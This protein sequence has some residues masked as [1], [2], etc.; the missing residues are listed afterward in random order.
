[1][2]A[3][4]GVTFHG[5]VQADSIDATDCVFAGGLQVTQTQLGCVRFSHLGDSLVGEL[6][7]THQCISAPP[8]AFASIGFE[9][10]EY[11]ALRLDVHAEL[12]TASSSGGMI[13]AY[14]HVNPG[15]RID[16]LR[17]RLGEFGPLG[18]RSRVIVPRGEEPS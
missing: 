5:P 18:Q 15:A 11:L 12:H 13:G 10:A 4:R 1:M 14:A 16:R 3:A 7:V 2:V 9:S 17:R 8:P 6:P